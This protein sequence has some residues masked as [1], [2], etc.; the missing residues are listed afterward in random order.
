MDFAAGVYLS[1]APSPFMT[2]C[3]PPPLH[4]VY[5]YTV[6]LWEGGGEVNQWEGQFFSWQHFALVLWCLYSYL[7]NVILYMY[8]KYQCGLQ[9]ASEYRWGLGGGGVAKNVQILAAL[10]NKKD[11]Q[12]GIKIWIFCIQLIIK[13]HIFSGSLLIR[14]AASSFDHVNLCVGEIFDDLNSLAFISGGQAA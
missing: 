12:G 7:V 1:E 3:S 8:S 5:V 4:T 6:Y 11:F 13:M 2:P 10:Y 9:L 14:F